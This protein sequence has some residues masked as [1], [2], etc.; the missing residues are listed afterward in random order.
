MAAQPQPKPA[1]KRR[2]QMLG[3]L[4]EREGAVLRRQARAH[5]QRPADAEDAL[6]DACVQFLRYYDGPVE[7]AI[8]WMQVVVKRCA[9]AIAR[10]AS[11]VRE[12][13]FRLPGI[14]GEA[15]DPEIRV[16]DE[17]PDPAEEMERAAVVA[18]R[19]EM[20]AEL[21]PDER[22]ALLLFASGHSYKEIAARQGWTHT[23]VNRCIAEGRA[24]L[25]RRLALEA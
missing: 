3:E 20:L 4:L 18:E 22:T 5:A 10:R 14:N 19:F 9:W 25:R 11:R 17:G 13:G 1:A 21:K 16:A 7:E 2:G 8:L 15:G 6:Q 24:A 23:K 12:T